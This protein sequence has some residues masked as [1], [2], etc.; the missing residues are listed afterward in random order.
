[1]SPEQLDRAFERF[2]RADASGNIPGT[3]LGLSLVKEIAE[4]HKGRAVLQSALGRGT[5]ASL[6]IPLAESLD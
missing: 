5:T 6:W 2:Y 4:L 3:G 1:M